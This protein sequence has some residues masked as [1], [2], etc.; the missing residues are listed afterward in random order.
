MIEW[1]TVTEKTLFYKV[2]V[3]SE[4]NPEDRDD[5]VKEGS[6]REKQKKKI[7]CNHEG[8]WNR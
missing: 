3:P 1:K 2:G 7:K 8:K 5:R 6:R 4:Q